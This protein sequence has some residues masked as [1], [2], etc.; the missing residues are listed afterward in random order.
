VGPVRY[1]GVLWAVNRMLG[2][3]GERG[4]GGGGGEGSGTNTGGWQR[5]HNGIPGGVEWSAIPA[6]GA[7]P[8]RVSVVAAAPGLRAAGVAGRA[9]ATPQVFTYAYTHLYMYRRLYLST[10]R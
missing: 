3:I 8:S 5:L 6:G 2:V 10:Y 9:K 4:G 7:G 1:W